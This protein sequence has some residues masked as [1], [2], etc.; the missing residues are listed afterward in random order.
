MR[1]VGVGEFVQNIGRVIAEV[2]KQ[3]SRDIG[4]I[5]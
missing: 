5:S 2:G 3:N 1:V 4:H